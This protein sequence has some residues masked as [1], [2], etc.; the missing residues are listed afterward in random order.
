VRLLRIQTERGGCH[1]PGESLPSIGESGI[2]VSPWAREPIGW[3]QG[4]NDEAVSAAFRS[5]LGVGVNFFDTAEIYNR[6]NPNA[7]WARASG[8]KPQPVVVAS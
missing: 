3:V 6:A 2:G 5:L 1:D 7:S 4:Q 8:G